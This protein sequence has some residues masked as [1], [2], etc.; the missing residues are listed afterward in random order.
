LWLE[1]GLKQGQ[2]QQSS[3]L[4]KVCNIETSP[5]K[6]RLLK[7]KFKKNQANFGRLL[8]IF[9]KGSELN[10]NRLLS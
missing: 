8:L 9:A 1:Q 7:I 10:F 6:Q 2:E 5:G 4:G 3:V